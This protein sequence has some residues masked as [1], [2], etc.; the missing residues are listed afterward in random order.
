MKKLHLTSFRF[1]PAA[2]GLVVA[3]LANHARAAVTYWDPEGTYTGSAT[4]V[5]YTGQASSK[6]PPVPGTMVGTWETASWS[7]VAT[8]AATPVAWVENTAACFAT[9]AGATNSAVLDGSS[10]TTFTVTMNGNHTV[11]GI[12]DGDLN[13]DSCIVTIQGS[14]IMTMLAG[15]L[16]GYGVLNSGDHSLANVIINVPIAGAA[17]AGIAAEDPSGAFSLNGANTYIGGTY[18]GYSGSTFGSILNFNSTASFGTGP[19]VLLRCGGGAF[20]SEGLSAINMTN[21]VTMY[22]GGAKPNGGVGPS[23]LPLAATLNVVGPVTFSGPWNMSLGSAGAGAN[24]YA[25]STALWGNYT[26]L[27]LNAGHAAN[28]SSDLVTI[29]GSLKGQCALT[30]GGSGILSLVGDNSAFSGPW[31]ITNGTTR[32]GYP[33]ALGCIGAV[34]TN[35]TIT[36]GPG[37]GCA[38]TLDLNGYAVD[39]AL[40]LNSTGNAGNGVLV[41]SNLTSTAV[42]NAPNG[43]LSVQITTPFASGITPP[44]TATVTGGGG[45]GANAAAS[46]GLTPASFTVTPNTQKYS[47]MPT[48]TVSSGGGSGGIAAF[49]LL[50]GTV[51]NTVINP[52]TITAPGFGYTS[53]PTVTFSGGTTSGAG[54]APTITANGAN[55]Q[56]M[57]IQITSSGSGYTSSPT[58]A[59]SG[60]GVSGGTAIGLISSVTLAGSASIGGPGNITVNSAIGDNGGGYSL[61]KIG[62]GTVTLGAVNTYSGATT[63]T[64]GK[65]VGVVGGSCASSAVDVQTGRTFGVVIP[66]STKQWTCASLTF[67][68]N[69]TTNEFNF[70]SVTPSTTLAPLNVTGAINFSG[71]PTVAVL[72]SGSVLA[73]TYPLMTAAGGFSGTV[74][75]TA[76]LSLPPHVVGSLSNDANTVYLVVSGNT[77]PLKWAVDG[78]AAWDINITAN[79]KDNTGT[80]VNYLESAAVPPVG[81]AVVFDDTYFSDARTVTLNTNVSPVA[82]TVN[83]ATSYTI[84]GTGGIGGETGLTKQNA[85]TLELD[86]VNTYSGGT[87]I[88]AGALT[89]GGAGQLGGG[90]YSAPIANNGTLTYNSTAPQTLSGPISGTGAVVQNGASTLVL[91]GA[92]SYGGGTT[93]GAA[94]TLQ[95]GDGV[96]YNGTTVAGNI[97][98]NGSLVF[99]KYYPQTYTGVLS[100]AGLLTVNGP[101]SLTLNGLNNSYSGGIVINAGLLV[102]NN[103]TPQTLSGAIS[104]AGTLVQAGAGTLTLSGGNTWSGGTTINTGTLSVNAIAD[105]GFSTS[106]LGYNG[107]NGAVG[108]VTLGSGTLQYTGA[109]AGTLSST[110]ITGTGTIDMPNGPLELDVLKGTITKTGNATLTLG[111]TADNSSLGIT[112]NNG[113]VILKKASTSTVHALGGATSVV[114]SG[115]LLQLSGT[116]GDQIFSGGSVTVNAGGVFD[117]NGLNEGYTTLT[118][119]GVG[120]GSG[121]LINSAA[122]ASTN[123]SAIVLGAD[124][125]V[126]GVGN[127]TLVGVISGAHALTNNVPGLLTLS[128]NSTFSGGLTIPAGKSVQLIAGESAGFGMTTIYGNGALTFSAAGTYTNGITAGPSSVVTVTTASG[129]TFLSG[130]LSSFTGTVNCNGGQI[131]INAANNQAHPINAAATWNIANGATLDLATPYVTD[132]ANVIV[133]GVGNNAFGCLRLDACNQTGPVLLNAANCT[134]GNGNAAASTISGIISDGG[135]GYGFTRTGTVNNTL[136][137]SAANTYTGPTTNTI[138]TL[139]ISATGSILGDVTVTVGTLQL[140]GTAN[141]AST[142]TLRLPTTPAAGTVNL[143]YTGSQ[144]ITALY[145]GATQQASGTWGAIGS[146]ATHQNAAFNASGPGILNVTTGTVLSTTN[147]ILSISNNANGTFSMEMLGTP[148]SIYYMTSSG[149]V[150]NAMS[151]WTPLAGTTNTANGSGNWFTV[152]SNTAPV[153]YRSTAVNPHP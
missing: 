84:S 31:V 24:A 20:V 113:T 128:G 104:G 40:I 144:T 118:L 57:G 6:A 129:N 133:N 64:G 32:V 42:L 73:G 151:A 21:T 91:S 82:V 27:Q 67:D 127:L 55:F 106:A 65:L 105:D 17:N 85:G 94:G 132:A 47:V 18:L 153:F 60:T 150:T 34:S 8:G 74:P 58:I 48:I 12:F 49:T 81:D 28:D 26:V 103:A 140:D 30:S 147:V 83:S 3:L 59:L 56:V 100:G 69:T 131:V 126:G 72:A 78:T 16:N 138:G 86:T 96:L 110:P 141:L 115:A 116:G 76:N 51:P 54:T 7:T 142:A 37:P 13:P 46:L 36:V 121:A 149:N 71:T 41:N 89:I 125:M 93:I 53:Q 22:N 10:T 52:V 98:D 130:D 146:S 61:T 119:N 108:T 45:S 148:G 68:D 29:A 62:A 136:V 63:V 109:G 11:A 33:T 120:S 143:T 1:I 101:T 14:G 88:S 137:L 90:T 95:I 111:G 43:V 25:S 117:L 114:N 123:T 66:D 139:D 70:G 122:G 99:A 35:G 44:V 145:F 38:G 4:Y 77:D 102:F 152:V 19:L 107:V 2:L 75:V 87:T 9:G 5:T 92:N 23:L 39:A 50:A 134:I 97:L 79:W 124:S 15:N 135:H 112:I 80:A